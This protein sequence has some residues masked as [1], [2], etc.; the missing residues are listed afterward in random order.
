VRGSW[1]LM[2]CTRKGD[3]RTLLPYVHTQGCR[4]ALR[5]AARAHA[6]CECIGLSKSIDTT[7][8]SMC[9]YAMP[10]SHMLM[11]QQTFEWYGC[12]QLLKLFML[13]GEQRSRQQRCSP[14]MCA[15]A[16][17]YS[18]EHQVLLCAI[19]DWVRTE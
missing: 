15:C 13:D 11:Y 12:I 18:Y 14:T 9:K 7:V 17:I 19:N 2:G 8:I 16:K 3:A 1:L 5:L 6:V 4:P 10:F